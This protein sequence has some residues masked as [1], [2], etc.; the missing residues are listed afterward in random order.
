MNKI[1]TGIKGFDNLVEGGIPKNSIVLINGTP[2][3]G[4]TIF[5][6]QYIYNGAMDGEKTL[7]LSFE[8][9]VNNLE[10]QASQFGWDFKK[11]QKKGVLQLK[12]ISSKDITTATLTD[13]IKNIK[14]EKITR[15]VIDSI[16]TLSLSIPAIH[17]KIT[18]ITDFSIKRFIHNFI[19]DLRTL[20][21]T[22]TLIIAQSKDEKMQTTDEISEFVADGIIHI[23]YETLGGDYSRTLIIRKMR[24]CKNDEDLHPLEITNKGLVVHNLS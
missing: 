20:T 19:E 13:L 14:R 24:Q 17:T 1:K 10:N 5:G 2:G 11:L 22:T 9:P 21:D 18:E 12:Y 15:L 8:E 7:Y 23:I 4:K 6:M 3:T 16:S